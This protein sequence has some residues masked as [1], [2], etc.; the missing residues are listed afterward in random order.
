MIR[1]ELNVYVCVW[2]S[3]DQIYAIALFVLHNIMIMLKFTLILVT[4]CVTVMCGI[5]FRSRICGILFRGALHGK[6]QNKHQSIEFSYA[7]KPVFV[8]IICLANGG[9]IKMP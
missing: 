8:Y 1:V 6:N 2:F 5:S 9:V 4:I 7:H 3:I